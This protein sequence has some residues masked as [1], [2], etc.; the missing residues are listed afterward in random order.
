MKLQATRRDLNVKIHQTRGTAAEKS[1][2][3]LK[4]W[5]FASCSPFMYLKQKIL[6]FLIVLILDVI[7]GR[8]NL[9]F[10]LQNKTLVKHHL[11]SIAFGINVL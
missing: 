4:D 1:V 11:H 6:L 7:L 8:F 9:F 5:R 3:S 2:L 10:L